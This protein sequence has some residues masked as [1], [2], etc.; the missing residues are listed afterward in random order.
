MQK[1]YEGCARI[2]KENENGLSVVAIDSGGDKSFDFLGVAKVMEEIRQIVLDLWDRVVF[3]RERK[4]EH[5]LE[6]ITGAFLFWNVS[7]I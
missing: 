2:H 4:F 3:F 7:V 6:L 5:R 1:M